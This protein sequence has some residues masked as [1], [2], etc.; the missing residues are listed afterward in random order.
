MDAHRPPRPAAQR[1]AAALI[2]VMLLFFIVSLVAA[3]AG[4]N[5]IFEQK[6]SANQY[7]ATQAFEAAEAG[8][9]WALAMLNGGRIDDACIPPA[10]VDNTL[11]SFRQRYL[12]IDADDGHYAPR[13]WAANLTRGRPSCVQSDTGWNC[14]CPTGTAPTP[15]IPAGTATRPAFRVCFEALNPPQPGAVRIV[16]TGVSTGRPSF[17][18]QPCEEGAEGT[19]GDAAATV[20]VVVAL[21]SALPAPPMAALTVVGDLWVY[22]PPTPT[23]PGLALVNTD[24]QAN[25]LTVNYGRSLTVGPYE[26]A[27][28]TVAG[29]SVSRS[30]IHDPDGLGAQ[31]AEELFK[32]TFRM[33]PDVYKRQP[34]AVVLNGCASPCSDVLQQAVLGNPGRV[35]WVNGDLGLYSELDLDAVDP[36]AL[37]VATGNVNIFGRAR[38]RGVLVGL[39]RI[40]NYAADTRVHGAVIGAGDIRN[41]GASTSIEYDAAVLKQ[42]RLASGSL[43][44]VPGSW[45]D[46]P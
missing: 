43:V 13:L 36:P 32:S 35:V 39:G 25:G 26:P 23:P 21:S 11:G 4:R 10:P 6:T 7:R 29:S 33:H 15:L 1:G 37:I 24:P 2:V 19:D 3:Y 41:Y 44:R 45:R 12:D 9:E 18:A 8:L 46:F 40:D 22:V 42:L 34:A 28:I 5:L 14:S 27:L 31:S 16:S 20:S 17:F 30:S 38:I